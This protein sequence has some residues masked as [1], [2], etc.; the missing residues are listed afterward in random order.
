MHLWLQP[1]AGETKIKGIYDLHLLF[2]KQKDKFW[3]ELKL[4]S[5]NGLGMGLYTKHIPFTNWQNLINA[6]PISIEVEILLKEKKIAY[7]LNTRCFIL[8]FIIFVLN[9]DFFISHNC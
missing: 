7:N 5:T 8:Y 6:F 3:Q 2:D 4:G 1:L 9:Q